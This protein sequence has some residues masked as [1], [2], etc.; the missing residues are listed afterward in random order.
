MVL[1]G[2]G[3]KLALICTSPV[4]FV[5]EW[6]SWNCPVC[7]MVF[8]S[9]ARCIRYPSSLGVRSIIW[10]DRIEV[11]ETLLHQVARAG[12][13]MVFASVSQPLPQGMPY[14]DARDW[15]QQCVGCSRRHGGRIGRR[16]LTG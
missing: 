4:P 12:R 3:Y 9:T 15:L 5:L 8:S 1:L 16:W 10:A 13:P 11:I 14:K 2:W 6:H 7:S